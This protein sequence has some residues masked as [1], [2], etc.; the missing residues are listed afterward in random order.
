VGEGFVGN[1]FVGGEGLG[2]FELVDGEEGEG[3]Y[4]LGGL[5]G[6]WGGNWGDWGDAVRPMLGSGGLLLG[7]ELGRVVAL[8]GQ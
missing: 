5:V 3:V 1:F 4:G 7:P 2:D 6:A 8:L